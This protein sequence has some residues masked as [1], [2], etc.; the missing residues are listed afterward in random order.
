[1][2]SLLLVG[3]D[4]GHSPS[5]F[6]TDR[7]ALTGP[8]GER[9]AAMAGEHRLYFYTLTSRTNVVTLPEQWRDRQLVASGVRR[10]ETLMRHRHTI[11]LGSR[12]AAAFGHG[13]D[14]QFAWM[15]T[16]RG[17]VACVPHP[18]GRNR[19]LNDQEVV[20]RYSQFLRDAVE[21]ARPQFP[22]ESVPAVP[23]ELFG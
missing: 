17:V 19:V 23:D 1:M 14:P 5:R 12:V 18:S 10:I 16:D 11:L 9:L 6:H 21:S 4:F 8:S 3:E 15:T 2:T 7:Y 13:A 22:H 20:R